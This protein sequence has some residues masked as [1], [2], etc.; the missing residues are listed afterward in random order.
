MNYQDRR[1]KFGKTMYSFTMK[2]GREIDKSPFYYYLL[3]FTWGILETVAGFFVFLFMVMM[4]YKPIKNHRGFYFMYG[5]N[6][7][8]FSLGLTQVIANDMG[9]AWTERTIRHECGHSY[10]VTYLGPLW[11]FFVGIP[12]QIRWCI[13]TYNCKHHLPRLDY[14]RAWFEGSATDLGEELVK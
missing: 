1:T 14:D 8:G 12:S 10:Q 5:S 11:F 2:W 4:G 13:D 9:D 6:W 7:G 3:M